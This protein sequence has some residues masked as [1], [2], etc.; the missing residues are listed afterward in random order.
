MSLGQAMRR[1]GPRWRRACALV[2]SLLLAVSSMAHAAPPL[3]VALIGDYED[4][5]IERVADAIEQAL[6]ES[7]KAE[8]NETLQLSRHQPEGMASSAGIAAADLVITIGSRAAS[9]VARARLDVATLYSFMPRAAWDELVACCATDKLP[10]SAL[11]IDQPLSRQFDLIRLMAPKASRIALLFGD[12]SA[13][14]RAELDCAADAAGYSLHTADVA[15]PDGIGSSLRR[16]VQDAD[17]LLALPDPRVYNR[18]TAYA[19]LLTTY[20]ARLPVIGFSDAMVRAGAAAA[21]FASPEDVG[22]DVA[23]HV[24]GYR[25]SGELPAAAFGDHFSVSVNDAVVRSLRL[26]DLSATQ[27]LHRL[28]ERTR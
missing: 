3:S 9:V 19:I 18:H 14:R 28:Q 22:R 15:D 20:S 6:S 17:L 23:R 21:V 5:R 26:P 10:H 7:C 25:R 24:R 2:A 8:C 13:H 27:L 11:F 16:L 1:A 12:V 4:V